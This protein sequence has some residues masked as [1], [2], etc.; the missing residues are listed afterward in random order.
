MHFLATL[1][2]GKT[3]VESSTIRFIG[4]Y[5]CGSDYG[6]GSWDG[7]ISINQWPTLWAGLGAGPLLGL[8]RTAALGSL[9]R[10]Q[11]WAIFCCGR[12]AGLDAGPSYV[13]TGLD[14]GPW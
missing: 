10:A 13:L 11:I 3:Q 12:L 4:S 5:F 1:I 2:L 8:A 6:I 7:F 14:A 9:D